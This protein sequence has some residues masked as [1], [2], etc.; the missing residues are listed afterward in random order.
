M[1][2]RPTEIATA[3]AGTCK[4]LLEHKTYNQWESRDRSL[5]WIKGKPGSGKSTLL[6][7]ARD[8]ITTPPNPKDRPLV[9]SFF[10]NGRGTKLQKSV[11]GLSRSLICQIQ[12]KVP[13]ALQDLEAIFKQREAAFGEHGKKWQWTRSECHY[14]FETA[15]WKALETHTILLFVDALDECDESNAQHLLERFS[16]LLQRP[17]SAHLK[18]FRICFT[19]RHYPVMD[20]NNALEICVEHENKRDISL[21]VDGKLSSFSE[22]TGSKISEYISRQAEGVFLWAS[23][24]VSKVLSLDRRL[25]ARDTIETEVRRV[26]PTL[27]DLYGEM[28]AKMDEAATELIEC[29]C[30]AL[31]PLSL[32]ELR[33]AITVSRNL[34]LWVPQDSENKPRCPHNDKEMLRQIQVLGHGLVEYKADLK[35]VQFIHLSVKDFFVKKGLPLLLDIAEP[36]RVMVDAHHRLLKICLNYVPKVMD[37]VDQQNAQRDMGTTMPFLLYCVASWVFHASH[38]PDE[39]QRSFPWPSDRRLP[40]ILDL[41]RPGSTFWIIDGV[42]LFSFGIADLGRSTLM[43]FFA[44]QGLT[45]A[46]KGWLEKHGTGLGCLNSGHVDEPTPLMF[47][48]CNGHETIVE[49]LVAAG[50]PREGRGRYAPLD[51][52]IEGNRLG[53]LE[54]ILEF[55]IVNS[56]SL[57]PKVDYDYAVETLTRSTWRGLLLGFCSEIIRV[58]NEPCVLLLYYQSCTEIDTLFRF[59]CAAY[60]TL[61]SWCRTNS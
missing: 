43:Q 16:S 40:Q 25:V 26:P 52:A 2:S 31:W 47:A 7:Y 41:Y 19:S 10:F 46:L 42:R 1:D 48:V 27:H 4:W 57:P 55:P 37:T 53:V 35:V 44:E 49:T 30:F 45:G 21:F 50:A 59:I 36:E 24:V 32:T 56:A 28:V 17:P 33:C 3:A 51:M 23:L 12:S 58:R 8:N 14:F 5:L 9:L 54:I 38:I 6:R 39:I 11:E 18:Q 34:G 60:V 22:R 61:C 20:L 15:L 13:K 29:I